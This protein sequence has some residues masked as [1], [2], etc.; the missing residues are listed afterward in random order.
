MNNLSPPVE[1][2]TGRKRKLKKL[3]K[4]KKLRKLFYK[5]STILDNPIER[6]S[7]LV[8]RIL[9]KVFKRLLFNRQIL[10]LAYTILLRIYWEI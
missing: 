5:Y 8:R 6:G 3:K 7:F 4:P 1:N 9:Y 2:P 10:P